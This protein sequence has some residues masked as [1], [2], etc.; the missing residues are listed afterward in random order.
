MTMQCVILG[1]GLGTRLGKLTATCP[2][3][4]LPVAGRPFI[5]YL[6]D[7]AIKQGCAE[8]LILAGYMSEIITEYFRDKSLRPDSQAVPI[9]VLSEAMPL[10]TGGA[11]R[12]ALSCL[13]ED[14]LLLNGDSFFRFD[15]NGLASAP[16]RE[17]ELG[18]IAT[19]RIS[20]AERYGTLVLDSS[21]R[22]RGIQTGVKGPAII[23]GGV[24]WFNRRLVEA[25]P[26]KAFVSL[27]NDVFPLLCSA[28]SLTARIEDAIFIDI[29]VPEAYNQAQSLFQGGCIL[30]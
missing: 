29:G 8:F 16:W 17:G 6:I 19:R 3:P 26:E 28:G 14:F 18:R 4:M 27:E 24:Y 11:L 5:D 15:W 30:A 13:K 2:K 20:D 12:N 7:Y 23:N 25:I 1:G 22:I 9:K 21:G 10:G